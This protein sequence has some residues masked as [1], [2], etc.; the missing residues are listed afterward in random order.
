MKKI[1]RFGRGIYRITGFTITG[2]W[3]RG[4]QGLRTAAAALVVVAVR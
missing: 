3:N 2:R 1:H 4:S